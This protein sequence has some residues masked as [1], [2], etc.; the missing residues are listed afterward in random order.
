MPLVGDHSGGTLAQHTVGTLQ[1]LGVSH[2]RRLAEFL[3]PVW[4][5][6]LRDL[7]KL[8]DRDPAPRFMAP[9]FLIVPAR[10]PEVAGS[11]GLS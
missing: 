10:R 9:D 5:F 2:C 6:D 11:L 1:Q 8:S 4:L 7:A 3:K